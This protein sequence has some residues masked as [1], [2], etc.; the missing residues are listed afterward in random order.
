[1]HSKVLISIVIPVKN[2]SKTIIKCL[3]A[4]KSQTLFNKCELIIIDSGSTDNTLEIVKNYPFV[5]L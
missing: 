4:V 1:M 3:D 2:A 5:R